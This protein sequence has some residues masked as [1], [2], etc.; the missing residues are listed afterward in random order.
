MAR[1]EA[2]AQ[3]AARGVV[4]RDRRE[5]RP[6]RSD[7][8]ARVD[9]RGRLSQQQRSAAIASRL[10]V[11]VESREIRISGEPSMSVAT[12]TN[13]ANGMAGI[14]VDGR[15]RAGPRRPQQGLGDGFRHRNRPGRGVFRQAVRHDAR[16]SGCGAC[17]SDSAIWPSSPCF[18]RCQTAI[19]PIL[20]CPVTLPP[21]HRCSKAYGAGLVM[22]AA[23]SC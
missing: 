22:L 16:Q 2:P 14:A 23:N 7:A 1:E 21:P 8:D 11:W 18:R 13:E 9:R 3:R 15:E 19:A 17:L 4:A 6:A 12:L 5:T 20:P 10:A